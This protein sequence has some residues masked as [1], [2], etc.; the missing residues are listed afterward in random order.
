MSR[1][2]SAKKEEE[3]EEAYKLALRAYNSAALSIPVG[4]RAYADS[5]HSPR[6]SAHYSEF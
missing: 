6:H 5:N 3:E 1:G 2:E 4:E